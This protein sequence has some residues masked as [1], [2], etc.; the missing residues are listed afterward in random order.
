M[1][2]PVFAFIEVYGIDDQAER[3]RIRKEA[4]GRLEK[5]G[6]PVKLDNTKDVFDIT[7][8]SLDEKET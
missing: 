6:F 8:I 1:G 4:A 7:P 3:R 5:L 2:K